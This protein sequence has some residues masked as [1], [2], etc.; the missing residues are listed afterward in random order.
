MSQSFIFAPVHG[1]EW[2]SIDAQHAGIGNFILGVSQHPVNTDSLPSRLSYEPIADMDAAASRLA[3]RIREKAAAARTLALCGTVLESV[4]RIR[5]LGAQVPLVEH[6]LVV[7][8]LAAA[9]SDTRARI[10]D[11]EYLA[12]MPPKPAG[13]WVS[14]RMEALEFRVAELEIRLGGGVAA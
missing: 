7:E 1:G 13:D 2:L 12:A 11:L 4:R 14:R 8:A 3:D 6:R 9:E 10:A 5:R